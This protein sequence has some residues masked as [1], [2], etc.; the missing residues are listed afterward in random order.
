MIKIIHLSD[1]HFH[2]DPRDNA[3]ALKTLA[4]VASTYPKHVM[5]VTGDIT[6]DGHPEQYDNAY[7]ALA[8][9]KGRL[10]L[11]PGN[12]DFGAAGNFYSL[13]RARR[14]D[15][16]LSGPLGQGS[17]FAGDNQPVV[18]VVRDGAGGVMFIALDTNLETD[19]P[20]DFACGKVGEIQL[21]ALDT[22]L[23]SPANR[24]LVKV[25][26]LHHHPFE[27]DDPFMKLLD[28]EALWRCAYLRVD[29]MLFGHKHVFGTWENK[30]GV[31]FILASDNSPGKRFAH[32]VIIDGR[33]ITHAVV[34]IEAN[35]M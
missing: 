10:F 9:F 35:T 3:A 22:L 6:D 8:P 4:F 21:R 31:R 18:N 30:N 33:D 19:T 12:H 29:V 28:A 11:C 2:R 14:F 1:L 15:E 26:L 20:F 16:K 13:E 5:V 24:D 25:L 27:R 32:E 17:S 7:E 23:S 34:P